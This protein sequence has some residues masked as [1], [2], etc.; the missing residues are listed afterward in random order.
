VINQYSARKGYWGA[1]LAATGILMEQNNRWPEMSMYL[2]P[3]M[4]ESFKN[5]ALKM[6]YPIFLKYGTHLVMALSMG[7]TSYVYQ[8]DVKI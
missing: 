8:Q 2:L 5:N 3:K 6:N 7:I 1:F 4:I